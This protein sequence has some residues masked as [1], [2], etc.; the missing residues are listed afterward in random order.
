MSLLEK[1]FGTY[2]ER[3]IKKLEPIVQKI[4]DLS[5]EYAA[6]DDY[7]LK[8]QTDIFRKRLKDGETTDDIL[9]EAYA[10]VRE[11]SVRVS[12]KR[13]FRVQLIGGIVLHQGRIA[14]MKTGEGKTLTATLPAYLNALTGE[15]VHI[16]TV[17]DYLAKYHSELMGNI[18]RFMGLSVGL[19]VHGLSPE[20]RRQAYAADITYGTNN[21]F[22]FDYL[23]DNMVIYKQDLVQRGHVYAIVDEVDSI[24]IDEARTPLIIS[25]QGE[26]SSELYRKADAF[27]RRLKCYRIKEFDSKKSDEDIVEDYIV[28]EKARS[29]VLTSNGIKKSEAHFGV[30]NL[31]DAENIEL[32]HYLNNAL[33]ARGVM[34]LDVDYVVKDGK[35]II[36]DAFTGRIMPGRRYSNGLHQAIEAKEGVEVEKE[37]KTQATITFQNYFRMYKKLSG[38]TGTAITEEPEFREIYSLDVVEIPT[39]KP[40]IRAD[41]NDLVYRSLEGKYTA[42]VNQIK[43]CH[44]KGQ[45]VLVG[46]VSIEKSELLSHLLTKE[47]IKHNVLNAKYHEREA[48]IVAQAGQPGAITIS[49]NMAGRGT[50]IM[51]GGNSEFLAMAQMKKEGYDEYLIYEATNFGESDDEE[52]SAARA[53]Y[54]QLLEKFDAE[55]KKDAELVKQAGGLY[56]LGTERHE[57]RRIDNQLRGRSGRQGD[58]GESRFFISLQDD[59]MRLF[60]SDKILGVVDALKMPEDQPINAKILS[61]S[62]EGA[63][64]RIEGQN[65]ERRKNVLQY[66]DVMNKQRELI[67][68]QRRAVLDGANLKETLLKMTSDYIASVVSAYTESDVADEWNFEGIR[69]ELG[70]ILCDAD[71]F[72]YTAEQLG[73]L[74]QEDIVTELLERAEKRYAKQEELFTPEVFREVERAVLLRTVDRKWV[75]HIDAMDDLVGSVGLNAYAQRNPIVEYKIQGGAMFDEMIGSIREETVRVILTVVPK[76]KIERQQVLV[77]NASLKD[78][79]DKKVKPTPQRKAVKAGPNDPCPCGSGRKYKKCCGSVGS[80]DTK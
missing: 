3:Q 46:T 47:G 50:D 13:P 44:E 35:V 64:K 62:I 12:G 4:E 5:D 8:S 34:Q 16:V 9:P 61:N 23:R 70:G 80:G 79:G 54:K 43:E 56:V 51:L 67:Y 66:D 21:E 75:D 19:I 69:G 52:I 55:I 59:L 18:Y 57:S 26:K 60:G 10:A 72:K 6:M 15:G 65:F 32:M 27:V 48:E 1:M 14:E 58:P 17:N 22:G 39:N 63:Q 20:Q 30:E 78:G 41:H 53:Q 38:M 36:V 25:G 49:T 71:D 68:K 76:K 11:A 77:G 74:N 31:G 29:A 45:P 37:N 7:T 24:L 73:S 40:M 28:D 33:R 42:I 2:S